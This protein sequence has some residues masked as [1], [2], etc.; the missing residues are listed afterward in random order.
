MTRKTHAP[1]MSD[2]KKDPVRARR[3]AVLAPLVLADR[4]ADAESRRRDGQPWYFININ[5][6]SMRLFYDRWMESRKT[7][8][9][10]GDIERTQFELSLLSN[11]ALIYMETNYRKQGRLNDPKGEAK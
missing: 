6:P 8:I 2:A 4:N 1:E 10:P 7:K 11:A 5:H 9:P 3:I